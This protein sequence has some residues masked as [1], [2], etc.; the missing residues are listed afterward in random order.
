MSN[1]VS[2]LRNLINYNALLCSHFS[3]IPQH[4]FWSDMSVFSTIVSEATTRDSLVG[5]DF[6]R[7]EVSDTLYK[8]VE[9]RL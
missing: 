4:P 8:L 6:F 9:F 5:V 1:L 2:I 3:D 7:I